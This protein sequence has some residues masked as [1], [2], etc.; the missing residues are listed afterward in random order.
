LS[1][2]A[3]QNAYRAEVTFNPDGNWGYLLD[4]T[5]QVRGRAEPFAQRDVNTLVK[6]AEP[7]LHPLMLLANAEPA[8]AARFCDILAPPLPEG[9]AL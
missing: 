7:A 3:S 9:S 6:V 1:I 2:G 4:T 5:L 8:T